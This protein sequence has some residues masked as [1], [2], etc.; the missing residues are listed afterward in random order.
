M[1]FYR[2]VEGDIFPGHIARA[3]DIQQIQTNIEEM[4]QLMWNT[5]HDH[6]AFVLGDREDDFVLTAAPK[7]GGRYIDTM[8][9]TSDVANTLWLSPNKHGY[10]QPINKCKS[11]TYAIMLS[12]RHLYLKDIK[13]ICHI[14]VLKRI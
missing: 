7:R 10:K 6:Q 2:R 8:N 11:S 5:M 3:E 12:L 1:N 9:I 4:S 14:I 13:W